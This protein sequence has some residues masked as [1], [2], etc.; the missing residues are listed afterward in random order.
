MKSD[1]HQKLQERARE[2]LLNQSYWITAIEMPSVGICN[3]WGLSRSLGY[4]TKAVEVK[5]SKQDF[6]SRSQKYKEANIFVNPL[7]NTNFI[8]CPANLIQPNDV[9]VGWGLLWWNGKRIVNKKQAKFI[10]QTDRQK[11][12]ILINLLENRV[13]NPQSRLND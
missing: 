4:I 1:L 6:R 7:A 9:K 11:L 2:Y 12:E 13:N 5:V 8:L 3:V 10:E